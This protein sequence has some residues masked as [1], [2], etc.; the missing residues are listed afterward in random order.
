[1]DAESWSCGPPVG[2]WRGSGVEGT[3]STLLSSISYNEEL[4]VGEGDLAAGESFFGVDNRDNCLFISLSR[5]VACGVE[6]CGCSGG[7]GAG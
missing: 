1:M 6:G 7:G 5:E 4:G 3:N 2:T